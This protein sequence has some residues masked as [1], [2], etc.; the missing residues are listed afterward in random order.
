[1]VT[2]EEKKVKEAFLRDLEHNLQSPKKGN[3][4]SKKSLKILGL[5]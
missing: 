2:K 4:F 1:M 5:S 3:E